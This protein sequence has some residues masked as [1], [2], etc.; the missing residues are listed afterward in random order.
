MTDTRYLDFSDVVESFDLEE[1][2]RL[3]LSQLESL[4]DDVCEAMPDNFKIVYQRYTSI[5]DNKGLQDPDVMSDVQLAFDDIC[6]LFIDLISNEFDFD[7]DDC[8]LE[9]HQGELSAIALQFYLFFVLNLRSN[10]YN[11]L[12]TFISRNM[13][14]LASQFEDL[15]Q[16]K[17]SITEI[18]KK[19]EDPNVALIASNIYD[20]VDWV[21]E[22][23]D[24]DTFFD[25]M[26]PDY[27]ALAPVKSM[28]DNGQMTGTFMVALRDLLKENISMKGRICFDII[29][30]LKGY[31]FT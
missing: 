17:D 24:E 30:K 26:E 3:L 14:Q 6:N 5:K 13:D 31:Q 7:V 9:D 18:N 12:L 22:N 19:M 10:L 20:V 15:K 2:R 28:F 11:V 1:T 21:M 23:M 4:H 25:C 29:C 27:I 16:R 8:Y